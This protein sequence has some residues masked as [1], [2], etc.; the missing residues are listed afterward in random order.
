MTLSTDGPAD[1]VLSPAFAWMRSCKD[2]PRGNVF[3]QNLLTDILNTSLQ[4]SVWLKF[5]QNISRSIISSS[6]LGIP[7]SE[8][9]ALADSVIAD[10]FDLKGPTL[11]PT[12][13]TYW[14]ISNA[15]DIIS[16]HYFNF[17]SL[18]GLQDDPGGG[19]LLTITDTYERLMQL[20]RSSQTR[21]NA[22]LKSSTFLG[23]HRR[24]I[25]WLAP[26]DEL[27][28]HLA[29]CRVDKRASLA[30]DLLGLAHHADDQL[31]IAQVIPSACLTTHALHKPTVFDA[32]TCIVY[33]STPDPSAPGRTV[34][35]RSLTEGVSEY[36]AAPIVFSSDINL[37]ML[38]RI[39]HRGA[40]NWNDLCSPAR[41]EDIS[42]VHELAGRSAS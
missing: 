38:G 9:S 27:D 25:L 41:D 17:S 8:H 37:I 5:L 4:R 20:K 16:P 12:C 15:A 24:N 34:D 10:G 32:G 31:L 23:G 28:G 33:R 35:L 18:G 26:G 13:S 30:R 1:V 14:R 7:F 6:K 11:T 21:Y 39:T 42:R 22:T 3:V 19:R 40:I 29:A 36:V 2:T